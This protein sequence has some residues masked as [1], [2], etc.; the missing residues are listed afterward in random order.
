MKASTIHDIRREIAGLSPKALQEIL[1]KVARYN[2]ENKEL[3]SY[4]LFDAADEEAYIESVKKIVDEQFS[5]LNKSNVYLAK[6][7]IRKV[8]RSINKY[9]KY[10]KI[11]TTE[12]ELRIYY[13][14]SFKAT[15]ISIS[16]YPV[17]TNIYLRQLDKIRSVLKKLHEDL[18]YDYSSTIEALAD[19]S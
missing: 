5:E 14:Q 16:K 12:I 1:S 13:L 3:I 7:T 17:L 10:S 8:L 6:K 18:Q 9:I 15:K 11:D 2:K 19:F 4:L